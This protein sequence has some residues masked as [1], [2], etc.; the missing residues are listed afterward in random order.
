[1]KNEILEE[2]WKIKDQ[3]ARECGNNIDTL[4]DKLRAKE[5]DEKVPV[6]DFTS[7]NAII[8][9]SNRTGEAMKD[10]PTKKKKPGEK[11]NGISPEYDA[12]REQTVL[13]EHMNQ[14]IQTIAEQHSSIV[15][16]LDQ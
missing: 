9:T 3:I 8:K 7:K 12:I 4:A 11:L 5:K 16:K 15:E 13:L 2:L 14:S 1:M 10:K 6:V